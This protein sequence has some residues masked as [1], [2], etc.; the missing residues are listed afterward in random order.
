MLTRL[1]VTLLYFHSGYRFATD[2]NFRSLAARYGLYVY[3]YNEL[4][5]SFQAKRMSD[6]GRK[7]SS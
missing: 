3:S 1:G 6:H 2:P 4:S 7:L 5:L